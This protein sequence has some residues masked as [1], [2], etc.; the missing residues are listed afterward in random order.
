MRPLTL[1]EYAAAFYD[2]SRP[3][4]GSFTLHLTEREDCL[5]P[6][7]KPVS[8]KYSYGRALVVAGAVGYSGAPV[9]AA[10]ACEQGGAGLTQ[11]LVP[12]SIWT[13]A[14]CRC[15]GAVVRPAPSGADGG[16][17]EAAVE[18]LLP[19][20]AQAD[21]CVIGPGL[22]RGQGAAR[23]VEAALRE[24]SCPLILDADA[25]AVCAARPELLERCRA[26]VLLTPHEGEFRR[27]GGDLNAGRLAGALSYTAAHSRVLLLLKGFGTLV[28]RG[29]EVTVNPTGSPALAK[30]GSG[31]VLAGLLC[32]LLAQGFGPL[33]AARCA[34]YLHGLAGDLARAELGEYSVNPSDIIRFL[35]AAF[36]A[37]R[38]E[39]AGNPTKEVL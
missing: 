27:L 25:L 37:L 4:P 33:F 2:E 3:L 31:D 6:R 19:L 18:Q 36:R 8:H 38:A 21:A 39:T 1:S 16:F 5:L 29:T 30:G 11:L 14:A 10:N 9:L 22:G 13:V 35:P 7:R 24:A 20:L 17:S 34:A 28:C 15:D 12:E 32:A 23:L 26:S